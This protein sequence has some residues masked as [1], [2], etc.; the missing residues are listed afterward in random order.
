MNEG[1]LCLIFF[2]TR[3]QRQLEGRLEVK[4]EQRWRRWR[5]EGWVAGPQGLGCS[6]CVSVWKS[7]WWEAQQQLTFLC[8][9]HA[10]GNWAPV[11]SLTGPHIQCGVPTSVCSGRCREYLPIIEFEM[12]RVIRPYK[13]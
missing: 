7:P 10:A 13:Y 6:V 11:T 4:I 5:E 8:P 3:K 2:E 12:S 1:L 9:H